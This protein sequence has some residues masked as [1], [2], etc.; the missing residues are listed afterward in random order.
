MATAI[1]CFVIAVWSYAKF[2]W[3]FGPAHAYTA[4]FAALLFVFSVVVRMNPAWATF[5]A[6]LATFADLI[7][8]GPTF[9]K[10][11]HHPQ[12]DS[13]TNFTFNSVK[14]IPALL[15]LQSYTTATMVYLLMLT[16]VNGGFAIFLLVRRAQLAKASK[17]P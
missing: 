15:A 6:I 13:V 16:N 7:N 9:R 14:C 1:A 12:E 10:M 5:A 2:T 3:S 4:V 17:S 8:Y 11:W